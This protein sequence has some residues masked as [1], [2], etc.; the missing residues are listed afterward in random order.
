MCDTSS[1][2]ECG[3]GG[4]HI[5]RS[6]DPRRQHDVNT[7]K[8]KP[9]NHQSERWPARTLQ[10][11]WAQKPHAR[12]KLE[13][14]LSHYTLKTHGNPPVRLSQWYDCTAERRAH[15]E[16]R[17]TRRQ[18]ECCIEVRVRKPKRWWTEARFDSQESPLRVTAEHTFTETS[19]HRESMTNS[20]TN[21]K[22]RRTWMFS[23]FC[24]QFRASK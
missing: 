2:A 12:A 4:F 13:K 7:E 1:R 15:W 24:W 11:E 14:V 20:R 8:R 6:L 3:N 10:W 21:T 22:Q 18:R 17:C 19:A 23:C 16:L 9:P 5:A